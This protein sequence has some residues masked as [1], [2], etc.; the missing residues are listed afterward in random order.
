L[1]D[2]SIILNNTNYEPLNPSLYQYGT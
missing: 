2:I 1:V